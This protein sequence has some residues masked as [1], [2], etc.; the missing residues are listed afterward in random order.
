MPRASDGGFLGARTRVA[1][2]SPAA[3]NLCALGPGRSH[4][5][6]LCDVGIGVPAFRLRWQSSL[7]METDARSN[8][9]KSAASYQ[10]CLAATH[11]SVSACEAQ[12]RT[13][14]ADE[15]AFKNLSADVST[16]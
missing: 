11:Q 9:E 6:P 14:D 16:K 8:Y 3:Y 13:M 5:N 7:A 15:R 12:R 1:P 4:D 2:A 10:I